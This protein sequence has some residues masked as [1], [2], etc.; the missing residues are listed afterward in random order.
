[1][2]NRDV[3]IAPESA[4]ADPPPGV[5]VGELKSSRSAETVLSI[6]IV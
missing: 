5:G 1:M 4:E 6:N 2:A 3:P